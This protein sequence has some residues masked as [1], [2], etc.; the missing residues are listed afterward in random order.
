MITCS[1]HPFP[2]NCPWDAGPEDHIVVDLASSKN[3]HRAINIMREKLKAHAGKLD[4]L[5]NN[6][7]IS[8]RWIREWI[9]VDKGTLP[10][11]DK[12]V[13]KVDKGG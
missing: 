3:T 1:R 2:E 9:R 10:L 8:P 11:V 4:A 12:G 13:D 7:A 6:A 5:V